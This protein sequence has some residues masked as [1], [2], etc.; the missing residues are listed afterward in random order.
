M[1]NGPMENRNPDTGWIRINESY[2]TYYRVRNGVC[3]VVMR[4]IGGATPS[5]GQI[6]GTLPSNYRPTLQIACCTHNL[7]GAFMVDTTGNI[8]ISAN[9]GQTL[10]NYMGCAVSYPI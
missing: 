1:A 4:L 8:S 2:P 6:L 9:S 10:N 7:R 3:Y 5:D